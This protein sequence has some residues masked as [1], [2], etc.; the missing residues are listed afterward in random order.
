MAAKGRLRARRRRQQG[1]AGR[2]GRAGSSSG[3]TTS[4]ATSGGGSCSA[5]VCSATTGMELRP[6]P[7][8]P[9]RSVG[10]GAA[11][12]AVGPTRRPR[13]ALCFP[14]HFPVFSAAP[15]VS[16]GV[17]GTLPYFLGT[18]SVPSRCLTGSPPV[19]PGA[20]RCLLVTPIALECRPVAHW[21]PLSIFLALPVP[22]AHPPGP[23]CCP[24]NVFCCPVAPLLV[25][26]VPL[27]IT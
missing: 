9:A 15:S 22:L 8:R 16:L 7:P 13:A 3:P 2:R 24:F 17:S 10:V 5:T 4:R 1:A 12:P 21:C 18:C 11:V 25:P 20:A 6:A 19:L 23:F 27:G 14:L 26:Q